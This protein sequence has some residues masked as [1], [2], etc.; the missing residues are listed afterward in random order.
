MSKR[1][2]KAYFYL[3]L[4]AAIWGIAGP[5]IKYTL[6]GL[7]TFTFLIYRFAI[8]ATF[9]F[10][11]IL[12]TKPHFPR[13]PKTIIEL[14][15]W[16]FITSTVALGFLFLGLEKTTVVDMTIITL[17]GPLMVTFA[18]AHFLHEHITKR[19]KAGTAIAVFGIILATIE[20]II[21][22][23]NKGTLTGNFL[24]ALS[25]AAGTL[26]AVIAKH[27]IRKNISPSLMVNLSFIIGFFSFLP[28]ALIPHSPSY[29]LTTVYYLPLPYLLGVLYMA[30]ISGNLAY[31]WWV[32]G[33]KT[34]EISESSLL[35]T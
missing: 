27:L 31:T 24:I 9:S 23:H 3:L 32:K 2:L 14:L 33:E 1:R 20:P 26:S 12:A 30:L 10:I 4:V 5:I 7:D 15:I 17:A 21:L 25:L 11:S 18:G 6:G 13:N 16:G 29:L 34:I 8:S 22:N 28:F 19:E 35:D